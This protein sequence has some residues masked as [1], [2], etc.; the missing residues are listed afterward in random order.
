MFPGNSKQDGRGPDVVDIRAD[1]QDSS[2]L[3]SLRVSLSGGAS[4]DEPPTFPSL[5][6]WN[7]RGLKIFEA[8]TYSKEYYLT[9][10]EID[11]LERYSVEIAGKMKP[12]TMLVELGSG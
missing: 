8:I 5:L 2:L 6:L 10:S 3:K 1:K 9:R 4:G 12:G 7:E 11:V